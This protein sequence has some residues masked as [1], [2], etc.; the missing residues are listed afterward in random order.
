MP[1][2][3]CLFLQRWHLSVVSI[4]S[5]VVVVAR[6]REACRREAFG[7]AAPVVELRTAGEYS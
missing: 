7:H 5:T 2:L 3:T 1:D 6:E 4:V